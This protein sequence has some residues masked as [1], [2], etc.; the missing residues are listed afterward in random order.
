MTALTESTSEA[1]EREG[2]EG[3]RMLLYLYRLS[4]AIVL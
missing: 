3:P 4:L 1:G 2:R